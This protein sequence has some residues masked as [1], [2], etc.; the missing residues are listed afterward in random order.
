M[1]APIH[2]DQR[3]SI[4]PTY[5]VSMPI[6][7]GGNSIRSRAQRAIE[8]NLK[9][10]KHKGDLS[11]KAA[12]R[13]RNS[14]NWLIH[15][16]KLKRV[17]SKADKK[18]Y[19]FKVNF[20]TLT[21]PAQPNIE[22][23]GKLVHKLL[24]TWLS[25]SRKYFYLH[26]YVWKIERGSGGLLHVHLTTDTFVHYRKLRDSWNRILLKEG[27]SDKYFEEHGHYDPNSTDVKTVRKIKN[28]AGY[29]SE[30]LAKGADLGDDF[31]NRIWGCN[32]NLSD[33]N[34]CSYIADVHELGGVTE[35]LFHRDIKWR[36]IES[37]PD[38]LGNTKSIGEIFFI[39]TAQWME[40]IRGKVKEEYVKHVELI[41]DATPK[42]PPEYLV[43][44]PVLSTLPTIPR[45]VPVIIRRVEVL[46]L[47]N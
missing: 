39:G 47:F 45:I 37:K 22:V 44:E 32:Y 8:S 11:L 15:S 3:F 30:Y 31:K 40:I 34:K 9:D 16:A 41:R 7:S 18:H 10:N 24:H 28:V 33:A 17:Y 27:L 36:R 35:S 43:M 20:I 26:N 23:N 29:L 12:K 6:Y 25:Y 14:I 21:I 42:P 2:T 19:W 4:R 1:A 5:V 46:E 13:I 38:S